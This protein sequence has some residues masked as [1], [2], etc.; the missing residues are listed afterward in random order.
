VHVM[1]LRRKLETHGKRVIHTLRG[2]GY[3]FGDPP[4]EF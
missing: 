3:R 2:R 4:G 1:D